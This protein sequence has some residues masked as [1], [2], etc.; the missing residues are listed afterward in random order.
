VTS[1]RKLRKFTTVSQNKAASF[2][3]TKES[4][5]CSVTEASSHSL[6]ARDYVVEA[7]T[8]NSTVGFFHV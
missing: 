7:Q 2:A 8:K 5:L 6:S 3:D 1:C 4:I